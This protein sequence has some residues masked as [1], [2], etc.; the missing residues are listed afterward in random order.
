MIPSIVM[1]HMFSI[2]C[3]F[4]EVQVVPLQEGRDDPGPMGTSIVV[5]ESDPR[6]HSGS[7]GHNN[8]FPNSIPIVYG[9]YISLNDVELYSLRC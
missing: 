3:K 8:R 7:H 9:I 6:S 1:V 5:H 4:G 2:G